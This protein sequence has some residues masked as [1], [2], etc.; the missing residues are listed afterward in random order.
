MVIDIHCHLWNEDVVAPL[1]YEAQAK[2]MLGDYDIA[3]SSI[4]EE[5]A[6]SQ[7]IS[8]WWSMT[9][10]AVLQKMNEAGIR[11]TV[12][13]ALDY[14]AVTGET[15]MSIEDQNRKLADIQSKYPDNFAFFFNVDP[16]RDDATDMCVRAVKEWGA[17]G[18]KFHSVVGYYPNDEVVYP[19]L[20]IAREAD[21][22]VLFH[23]GPFMEPFKAECSHPSY[24]YEAASNF[25]DLMFIV[26][27]MSFAWWRELIEFAKKRD[28]LMC[29]FSAWQMVAK[30]NYGQFRRV[31]RRVMDG[32]GHERVMFGTDGPALD[33]MISRAEWVGL[34]RD[35]VNPHEEGSTFTETEIE[36]ILEGNAARVLKL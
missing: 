27:H 7:I 10:D 32:F 8:T 17:K 4:T 28:N 36:A 35:L 22:P 30:S 16:R 31:L 26:A 15:N 25:P 3:G 1:F 13:F 23:S 24:I 33:P 18:L 6:K 29:D 20:E 14:A 5:E 12:F 9:E 34:V 2:S 21:I 19:L 11:L